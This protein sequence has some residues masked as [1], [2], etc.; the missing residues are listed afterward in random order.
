[1][2]QKTQL[3]AGIISLVALL[4]YTLIHTGGLLA[5]YIAP[6]Q[7]GYV[8][9]LGI[10]IAIVSLSLRI[11]DLRKSNLDYSFFLFV[12]I[13]VVVVSALAN[14]YEGFHT[15]YGEPLTVASVGQLDIVQAI[16]GL[17]ATGLISLIVLALSEIIGSDVQTMAAA[18]GR[19]RKKAEKQTEPD[20]QPG[21]I[22]DARAI[23]LDNDLERKEDR[24]DAILD[25]Y[26]DTPNASAAAVYKRLAIP[27]STF[28]TYLSELEEAGRIERNGTGVIVL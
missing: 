1:M 21:Q 14:V 25:T 24:I 12:L 11:G 22:Q 2:K 26:R 4:T 18:V 19:A 23:D 5:R 28:Y 9:A 27:R 20:S 7:A 16:V 10:E 13:S 6:P 17:S 3:A 15:Y 8:A